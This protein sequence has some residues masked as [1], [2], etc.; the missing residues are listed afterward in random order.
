[1][2]PWNLTPAEVRTMRQMIKHGGAREVAL[3]EAMSPDTIHEHLANIRHKFRSQK[4]PKRP[5]TFQCGI[6]FD[7][8]ERG[9]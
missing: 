7:R 8:W 3:A 4:W 2:N 5:T 1:M 6:L 9:E